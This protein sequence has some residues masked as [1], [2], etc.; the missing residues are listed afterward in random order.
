MASRATALRWL[1][2]LVQFFPLSLFAAIAW[3]HGEPDEARWREAFE[4]AAVA[5]VLQL[6]I[7]LPQSR[8]VNRLVLAGNL[9]LIFGGGAFLLQQWWFLR[10]YDAMR[11]AAIFLWMLLVGAGATAFTRAGFVGALRGDASA[12]VRASTWLLAATALAGAMSVVFRGDRWWA[13]IVPIVALAILQRLLV[14]RVEAG[15]PAGPE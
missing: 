14:R 7:V 2:A 4:I 10:G 1:F 5:G 6:L 13:A 11:E 8:P 9:Y 3:R 12:I 15:I